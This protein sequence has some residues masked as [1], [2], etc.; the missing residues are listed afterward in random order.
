MLLLQGVN[1]CQVL[2]GPAQSRSEGAV[3]LQPHQ[4][5]RPPQRLREGLLSGDLA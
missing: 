4:G 1:R 3:A 2:P 5:P